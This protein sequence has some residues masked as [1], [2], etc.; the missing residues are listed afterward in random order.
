MSGML[1]KKYFIHWRDPET[2]QEARGAPIFLTAEEAWM[3]I[4]L[5]CKRLYPTWWF[6]VESEWAE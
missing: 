6:G 2:G 5:E 3:Y 4:D 1:I